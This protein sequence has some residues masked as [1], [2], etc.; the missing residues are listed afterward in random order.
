MAASGHIVV[1]SLG[2]LLAV[3]V[4]AASVDDAAAAPAALGRLAEQPLSRLRLVYA[5]N[6]YHNHA[7]YGWVAEN[8]HY[9]RE[10]VRGPEGQQGW[11]RLP[12]RRTVERTFAWLMKCRRLSVDR[13]KTTAPESRF[14]TT[15][16]QRC[17]LAT[18]IRRS[19]PSCGREKRR[20]RCRFW[21][22]L[23]RS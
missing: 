10:I 22:S 1:D 6:K 17:P 19:W 11:V 12:I 20:W 2:L 13:E 14:R 8:G 18:A 3:I 7:L 9:K 21:R 23:I 4:T 5:D 15:V 16:R